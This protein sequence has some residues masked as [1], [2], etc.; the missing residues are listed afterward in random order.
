MCALMSAAGTIVRRM[1]DVGMALAVAAL[2]AA[3]AWLG[4]ALTR[5]L[6]PV[7]VIWPSNGL[8]AALLLLRRSR[9]DWPWILAACFV[10]NIAVDV[11]FSG[12]SF[13]TAIGFSFANAV[14]VLLVVLALRASL[15]GMSALGDPAVLVRFFG[16]AVVGAPIVSGVLAA[17]TLQATAGSEFLG[18]LYRWW[19]ADALGMAVMLPLVLGLQPAELRQT[20]RDAS[21]PTLFGTFALAIAMKI[22]RAHV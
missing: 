18:T 6:G 20:V 4:I 15:T 17:L 16:Y 14:E 19:A 7:A 2:F 22:G 13:A 12:N 11:S 1:K 21:W 5:E 3:T 10:A 8:L 9:T